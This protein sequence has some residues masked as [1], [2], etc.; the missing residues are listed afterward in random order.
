MTMNGRYFIFLGQVRNEVFG[1]VL[2]KIWKEILEF[3]G[4]VQYWLKIE[5]LIRKIWPVKTKR[6]KICNIS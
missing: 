3:W 5:E 4:H 1:A 2:E 6:L